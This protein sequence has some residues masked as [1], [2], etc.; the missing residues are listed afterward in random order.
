[1]KVSNL[2]IFMFWASK[3]LLNDIWL[4]SLGPDGSFDTHIAIFIHDIC[5]Y[6]NYVIFGSYDVINIYGIGHIIPIPI[7]KSGDFKN[8]CQN[9][10]LSSYIVITI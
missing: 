2:K 10:R 8:I 1:M 9:I 4:Q 3:M 6:V 5:Y 7:L